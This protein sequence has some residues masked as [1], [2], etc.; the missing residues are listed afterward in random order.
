MQYALYYWPSIPGRGEFVRLALEAGG[1]TYRDVGRE[2]DGLEQIEAFLN[3]EATATPPF[4]PPFLVSETRVI[5]HV[6]NILRTL[7]PELELV[8]DDSYARDWAHSLQ[9]TLTDFVAEIHDTHHPLGPSLYFDEQ[10]TEARRRAV[11][12]LQDRLPLFLGYFEQILDNNP[13]S[14]CHLVGDRLSYVDT[15]LF[16]V[17]MGLRYAFPNAMEDIHPTVAGLDRVVTAVRTHPRLRNYLDSPRRQ[18]F[19]ENGIFR[20]YPMLDQT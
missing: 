3:G 12:F 6:A 17:M 18:P 15:S 10:K 2:P 4:A 11:T 14:D 13:V 19:N 9:L 7:G 16:Q 8:P 1:A 20:H 5:S